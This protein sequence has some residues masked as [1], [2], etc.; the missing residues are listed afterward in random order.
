MTKQHNFNDMKPVTAHGFIN[1]SIPAIWVPEYT[2]S[3][4]WVAS[5]PDEDNGCLWIDW[6]SLGGGVVGRAMMEAQIAM[7]QPEEGSREP[8]TADT[9]GDFGAF[10]EPSTMDAPCGAITLGARRVFDEK[11]KHDIDIYYAHYFVPTKSEILM[12]SFNLVVGSDV[13]QEKQYQGLIETIWNE[14]FDARF[15]AD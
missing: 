8:D 3:G 11:V 12:V 4:R 14:V 5:E 10:T 9:E 6:E 2:E 7:A 13:A 1:L 15:A